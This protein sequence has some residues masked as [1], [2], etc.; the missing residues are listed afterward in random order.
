MSEE[1]NR[2]FMVLRMAEF[3]DNKLSLAG[4]FLIA[5]PALAESESFARSVIYICSHSQN[6]AMGLIITKRLNEFTFSD[7]M[8]QLPIKNYT[9]LNEVLLYNGGPLEKVRGMVL[10]SDDYVKEGTIVVGGGIAVSSTSEIISDIAFDRGPKNKLVA[11][12][13]SFWQP[14]QLEAEIYENYWLVAEADREILFNTSD[15]EKWQR[16]LDETKIDL[17]SFVSVTGRA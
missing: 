12:G 17:A 7:L 2:F 13:Y 15:D 9:R 1:S 4:K 8:F 10:H 5:L 14:R 16:A 3:F 11:L 6:G